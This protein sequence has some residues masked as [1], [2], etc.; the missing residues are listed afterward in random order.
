ML[1]VSSDVTISAARNENRLLTFFLRYLLTDRVQ[2]PSSMGYSV[3]V[4]GGAV[5]VV[6][7]SYGLYILT[8]TWDMDGASD[9][10]RAI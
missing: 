5:I 3:H 6:F 7:T 2:C 10:V 8:D 4:V 9:G 1:H